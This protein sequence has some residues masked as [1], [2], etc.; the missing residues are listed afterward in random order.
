[1]VQR[2]RVQWRR[3]SAWHMADGDNGGLA[4][5]PARPYDMRSLLNVIWRARACALRA[6]ARA[7][8]ARRAMA[9]APLR[10]RARALRGAAAGIRARIRASYAARAPFHPTPPFFTHLPLP[11]TTPTSPR[12]RWQPRLRAW[13]VICARILEQRCFL[14]T[15]RS[16]ARARR[17]CRAHAHT[18]AR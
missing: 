4:A 10:A 3:S 9:C 11:A 17:I 1:M 7:L 18:R 6:Y 2:E 16:A 14:R 13:L 12:A 5:Y 15:A 8:N